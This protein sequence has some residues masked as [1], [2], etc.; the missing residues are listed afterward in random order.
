MSERNK[1][2]L[3]VASIILLGGVLYL[4]VYVALNQ[5]NYY[6]YGYPLK[7][8]GHEYLS[9]LIEKSFINKHQKQMVDIGVMVVF[10]VALIKILF[11]PPSKIIYVLTSFAFLEICIF[12]IRLFSFTA[13]KLPYP[14]PWKCENQLKWQE[15]SQFPY[16]ADAKYI[17]GDYI[18]SG[19]T[20]HCI[21]VTLFYLFE[22]TSY[23]IEKIFMCCMSLMVM[24]LLV[25]S[26][27]HYTVDVIL[28]FFICISSF[29]SYKY[30]MS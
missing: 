28:S 26:K 30:F 13:T 9:P 14:A 16:L 8:I 3:L 11:E 23:L 15:K 6:R 29:F 1:I 25:T 19:H 24:V 20:A 22:S 21:L 4:N 17:C 2:I 10:I 7:D 5:P 12:I 27:L 18:F